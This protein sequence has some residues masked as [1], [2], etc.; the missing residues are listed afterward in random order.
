MI[1][2]DEEYYE[3]DGDEE[4]SA[5]DVY[6]YDDAV[7]LIFRSKDGKSDVG[8]VMDSE[9]AL[10]L[11]DAITRAAMSDFTEEVYTTMIQ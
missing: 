6:R 2:L 7:I 11:A 10:G 1:E 8:G 5:I 9:N 4:S 3:V